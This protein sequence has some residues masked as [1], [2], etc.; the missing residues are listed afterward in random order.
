MLSV[1]GEYLME[2]N[3][4][5]RAIDHVW[6]GELNPESYAICK[7]DILIERAGRC[8]YRVWQHCFSEDGHQYKKFDYMPYLIRPLVWNGRKSKRKFARN[9][10][11]RASMVASALVCRVASGWF[12]CFSCC[13]FAV[14]KNA[15][16]ERW[17]QPFLQSCSIAR[18]LYTGA[19][20]S[21]KATF[22]VIICWRVI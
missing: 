7:A 18:L 4:E 8:Q 14:S 6:P 1:A 17:G 15:A 22:G 11:R 13:E 10:R 20:G 5:V 21:G 9:M 3:P 19:A 2:H 12:R 16:R